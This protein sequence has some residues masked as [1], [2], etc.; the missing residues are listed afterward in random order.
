MNLLEGG[1]FNTYQEVQDFDFIK[2]EGFCSYKG[3]YYIVLLDFYH[4]YGSKVHSLMKRLS[5]NAKSDG[6]EFPQSFDSD[7]KFF[8]CTG[9]GTPYDGSKNY[10]GCYFHTIGEVVDAM[11]GKLNESIK[12]KIRF[13]LKEDSMIKR[14]IKW[15]PDTQP[16]IY[17]LDLFLRKSGY[18]LVDIINNG[19]HPEPIIEAIKESHLHPDITFIIADQTFYV[20]IKRYGQIIASDL[21]ELIK[22]YQNALG[23]VKYLDTLDLSKLEV[24]EEK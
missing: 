23:V 3:R 10:S 19:G 12:D 4:K 13:A 1:N 21:E 11:K 16:N 5:D 9:R 2:G 18:R 20:D 6:Y 22:G 14:K 17:Q 8:L 24:E 7:A 15:D